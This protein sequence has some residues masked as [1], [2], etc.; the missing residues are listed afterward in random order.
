[1]LAASTYFGARDAESYANERGASQRESMIET[2][3]RTTAL[4]R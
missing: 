1:M 4:R 3:Q 2:R